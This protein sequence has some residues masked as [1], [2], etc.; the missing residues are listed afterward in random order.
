MA[1]L[2][3]S[4]SRLVPSSRG[5]CNSLRVPTGSNYEDPEI[6][7]N[8]MFFVSLGRL[9]CGYF[10]VYG[11]VLP[12]TSSVTSLRGHKRLR[13]GHEY[14]EGRGNVFKVLYACLSDPAVTRKISAGPVSLQVGGRIHGNQ[15]KVRE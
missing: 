11:A 15:G 14:P 3:A 1:S 7:E 6:E 5:G 12:W 13:H 2:E 9:C 8:L 10:S 4:G